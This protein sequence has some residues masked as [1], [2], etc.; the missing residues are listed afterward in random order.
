V[1]PPLDELNIHHNGMPRSRSVKAKV[2]RKSWRNKDFIFSSF[3][4]I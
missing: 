4:G 2:I 1:V 3:I